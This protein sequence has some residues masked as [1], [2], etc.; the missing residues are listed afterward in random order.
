MKGD[1]E[2]G[3]VSGWQNFKV[4]RNQSESQEKTRTRS[5]TATGHKGSNLLLAES[6]V[7]Q[8]GDR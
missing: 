1:N 6:M 5:K 8:D 2:Q 3:L 4:D 7:W